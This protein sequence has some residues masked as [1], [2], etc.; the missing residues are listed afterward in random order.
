MQGVSMNVE[1]RIMIGSP[2]RNRA[3]ILPYYLRNLYNLTYNKKAISL[4]FLVNNSNDQTFQILSEFA[5]AHQHE[6]SRIK[7][8]VF[9]NSKIPEDNRNQKLD[10]LGNIT[11]VRR[12][13]IY[14]FLSILR[15]KL[16]LKC[17]EWDCDYLLSSDSDIILRP[18][19]IDKL[20]SHDT[21]VCAG[22][23]YNGYLYAQE[24]DNYMKYP[25][26]LKRLPDGQYQH[27][28][29][30]YVK[31]KTGYFPVDFSGAC[32]LISKAVCKISK[33]A[34]DKAY[35]EDLPWSQSVQAAGYKI[36]CDCSCYNQH[37][38]SEKLLDQ[39]KN[40]GIEG[41]SNV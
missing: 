41:V 9:D 11:S 28:Y 18:D 16:L 4:Y 34:P 30:Y 7:I 39:F 26:I 8:D 21:A 40:F 23:I 37:V 31:N 13:F 6:Y 15:N 5:N 19:C 14:D 35:G 20:L 33:Y 12:E 3:W 1:K 10:K 29:N 32:I 36:Y 25:N 2:C 17:V 22:L 38:M 24:A 27:I